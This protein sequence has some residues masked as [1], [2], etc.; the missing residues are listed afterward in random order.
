[1][2]GSDL[3]ALFVCRSSPYWA[4]GL[5]CYDFE[6]DA[7]TYRGSGR[8]ICHPPCRAWGRYAHRAKAGDGERDLALFALDLVRRNGGVLEHPASSRLWRHLLP[9]ETSFV[10]RQ[11]DFGHRAEKL[12][13]LFYARMPRV[14]LLPEPVAGPFVPVEHMGRQERERTPPTLARWLVTWCQS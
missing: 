11:A 5:D 2:T 4:L 3:A 8:V 10:V 14:P 13:R 1:M 9:G 12:T 6:R 7:R